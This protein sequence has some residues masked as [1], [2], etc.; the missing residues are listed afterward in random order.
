MLASCSTERGLEKEVRFVDLRGKLLEENGT[1]A[2]HIA[3][4]LDLG[5]QRFDFPEGP[6]A[7]AAG[8]RVIRTAADGSFAFEKVPA[9]ARIHVVSLGLYED[10]GP[11][12]WTER[13]CVVRGTA[14]ELSRTA[15]N[16]R[17]GSGRTAKGEIVPA[18]PMT[19][20]YAYSGDGWILS[21][22]VVEKGTGRFTLTGL[23]PGDA[24]LSFQRG[25]FALASRQIVVP[26]RQD[27][28]VGRIELPQTPVRTA[29]H[30]EVNATRVRLVDPRGKPL[31][32]FRFTFSTPSADGQCV[33]DEKGELLMKGGGI[34]I[35]GPPFR[36]YLNDIERDSDKSHYFGT[37]AEQGDTVT[38]TLAP[39]THVRLSFRTSD[40]PVTD[41][42]VIA[43]VQNGSTWLILDPDEGTFENRLP[44]G[45]ARLLVG[46]VQG[47]VIEK[48]LDV[49]ATPEHVATIDL[50]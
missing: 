5:R 10:H 27:L 11:T 48:D 38:V 6:V 13:V 45:R 28:D 22:G 24:R 25:N 14:E 26:E 41:L 36:L 33:S 23:M 7:L 16:L 31:P 3:V 44:P 4:M 2:S 19:R 21:M 9:D 50:R 43:K 12:G 15:L 37:A 34:L 35:G 32:G 29:S 20:V 46:T 1:P 39:L 8:H 17:L 49:P 18:D 42:V 30:P 40:S 47:S